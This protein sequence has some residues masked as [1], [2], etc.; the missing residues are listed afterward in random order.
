MRAQIVKGAN[1][2][3]QEITR[4]LL[5]FERSRSGLRAGASQVWLENYVSIAPIHGVFHSSQHAFLELT[6]RRPRPCGG[7]F[8][9]KWGSKRS[10]PVGQA[11]FIPP[12]VPLLG[13]CPPGPIVKLACL[14]DAALFE[15]LPAD[16]S[17]RALQHCLDLRAP[18]VLRSLQQIYIE[19]SQP[20]LGGH[21]MVEAQLVLASVELVR[22]LHQFATDKRGGLPDWKVRIIEERL[23]ADEPPPT[24]AELAQ[25]CNMSAR[26]LARA[27][28]QENGHSI[29]AHVRAACLERAQKMLAEGDLTLKEIAA[30]LGFSSRST[31][32]AAY[33]R[34]T[35]RSP[36]QDRARRVSR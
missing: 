11:L 23:R 1:L 19:L 20:K 12:D 29:S 21:L 25:L 31:F 8:Y 10:E 35:G 4:H 36:L 15:E 9:E 33:R 22:H 14:L 28:S 26:H 2:N 13:A 17:D 7:S 34:Q 3:G 27:F 30:K 18:N 32:S 16:L 24:V 5:T 6:F